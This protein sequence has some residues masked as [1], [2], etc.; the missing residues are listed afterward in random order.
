MVLKG[1]KLSDEDKLPDEQDGFVQFTIVYERRESE[2]VLYVFQCP[3]YWEGCLLFQLA[4][5]GRYRT[6]C[7]EKLQIFQ[8]LPAT[9][10]RTAKTVAGGGM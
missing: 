10:Q 9:K 4:I 1:F 5:Q 7:E 3:P 6:R 2:Q 8:A